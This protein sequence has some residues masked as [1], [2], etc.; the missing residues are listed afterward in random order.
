MAA[1]L[2]TAG[3]QGHSPEYVKSLLAAL[4][5]YLSTQEALIDPL[6][7]RELV[8]LSLIADGLTNAEIAAELVIAIST[9]KTHINRIYGKLDVRTRSQAVAQARQ[10]QILP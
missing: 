7:E 1:L 5:E 3:A 2:R 8:V 10:L 9:V 4:G 6:S